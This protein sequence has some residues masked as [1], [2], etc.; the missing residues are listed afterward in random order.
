LSFNKA[1]FDF[2]QILLANAHSQGLY[3]SN[4]INSMIKDSSCK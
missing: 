2:C 4:M 3:S 1:Q